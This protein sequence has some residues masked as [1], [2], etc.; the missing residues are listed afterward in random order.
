MCLA[1]ARERGALSLLPIALVE[2]F[3][4]TVPGDLAAAQS[5]VTEAEAVVDATRSHLAPQGA[6]ALAAWRGSDRE[7]SKLIEATR[8]EVVRRGEGLWLIA[9]EWA[10][11]V[12]FNSLGRYDE[13]LAVSEHAGEDSDE[14]G[15][16]T[17]VPT[18]FIEAA[19]RA[20]QRERAAAPLERLQQISRAS[21]SDWALGVEA[22]SRA[23]LSHG[24]EAE[25]LY[26]EAIDRLSRTRI[27]IALARA[28]L[29]YGEMAAPGGPA[30][31]CS[32]AVAHS[33]RDVRRDRHG[34]VRRAA[35]SES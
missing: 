28:A 16:S 13:A 7:V 6:I 27:K 17:W 8:H 21:G 20:G 12:L 4:V 5:L 33:A 3:G 30:G 34:G 31:G 14:L 25:G 10:S 1:L 35:R 29:L 2:R 15:L 24:D 9:T 22:R 19:V 11:A 18:E 32:R 23:L 26:R